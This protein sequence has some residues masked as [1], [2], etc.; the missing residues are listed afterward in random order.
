[1]TVAEM[2]QRIG[3]SEVAEWIAEL[4][5]R[6]KEEEE[7]LKKAKQAPPQVFGG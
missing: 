1:M 4:T 5:L 7:A 3:S 6:A 2:L